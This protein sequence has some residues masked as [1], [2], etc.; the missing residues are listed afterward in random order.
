[1]NLPIRFLDLRITDRE[2][3]EAIHSV[4]DAHMSSGRFIISDNGSEFESDFAA[5]VGRKFCV[6]VNSGTDALIIGL[7]L[8]NLPAGGRVITSPFSWIASSTSIELNELKPLFV[9][10]D[11]SLQIDLDE[12]ERILSGKT[13]DN[14]VAIM[15]PHLHGNVSDLSRLKS[16]RE[17]FDVKI[18]EDCA[19]AFR[20]FDLNKES[21]GS[22]GDVSAFSFNAMKVLG[23]L[24]DGGAVV[25]D[26]PKLLQRARALRHSGLPPA[27]GD[28]VDLSHNCR[29]DLVH[30]GILRVRMRYLQAKIAKRRDICLSY[31]K[32]LSN[33]LRPITSDPY[34]S[35][36]Y[37]YQTVVEKRDQ[38]K[39]WLESQGIETRI[40]HD[41]L[42][43]DYPIFSEL[44][45][46]TPLA[47]SLVKKT[48]CLPIHDKLTESE[49]N[50]VCEAVINYFDLYGCEAP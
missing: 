44:A 30:G 10:V 33:F 15:V 1:V 19:Q 11:R 36:H 26:D 17:A 22:V 4:V 9:D 7:R 43:S 38:L 3:R 39:T 45:L 40:R 2:E 37:C 18:I 48:L 12:V 47:S 50:Y 28:L 20:A 5:A 13:Y 46:P 41:F 42:I 8:L 49:V 23:G 24:G 14:V 35:N 31:N 16:L 29:L 6:G 25:F 34:L 27:G 32:A 21:A